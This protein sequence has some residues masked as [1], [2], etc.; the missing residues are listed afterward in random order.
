MFV[1]GQFSEK[2]PWVE[3]VFEEFE[4][5]ELG[6]VYVRFFLFWWDDFLIKE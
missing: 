6:W 5:A 2:D 3:K 1:V 4:N